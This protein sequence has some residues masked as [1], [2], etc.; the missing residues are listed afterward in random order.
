M[1]NLA[2]NKIFLNHFVFLQNK[3]KVLH[4]FWESPI[5]EK[6][7]NDIKNSDEVFNSYEWINFPE[8]IRGFYQWGED[9][10]SQHIDTMIM[11]LTSQ[12]LPKDK[13]D[14]INQ[15]ISFENIVFYRKGLKITIWAD[16]KLEFI[17]E[18]D[19]TV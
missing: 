19:T 11:C 15:K 13:P 17:I 2:T 1:N 5:F 16:N 9:V 12:F 18:K 10:Y 6:L 3:E 4:N 8:K 7:I 14:E